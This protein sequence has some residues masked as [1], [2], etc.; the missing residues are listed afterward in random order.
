MS[1]SSADSVDDLT[2]LRIWKADDVI[3]D[4]FGGTGKTGVGKGNGSLV[5]DVG[6][7]NRGYRP[8]PGERS[9]TKPEW[10]LQKSSYKSE[11]RMPD[12]QLL[13]VRTNT[14]GTN[15]ITEWR[16]SISPS[17]IKAERIKFLGDDAVK[18]DAGT[19]RSLDGTRQFRTVPN[20]YLGKHGIGNP[21]VPN[22][23]HVHFE[24]LAP[25]NPG[26]LNMRVVKNVHV[27][28]R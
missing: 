4:V 12:E 23:P 6:L 15:N 3:D 28:I 19:W 7:S 24:F 17:D 1:G 20:D 5:D 13:R 2:K 27:P 10:R 26:A 14:N 16:R 8:L 18:V 21:L 11:T 22:T 25:P 9:M